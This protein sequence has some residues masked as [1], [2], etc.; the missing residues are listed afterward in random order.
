[1][2]QCHLIYLQK[3]NGR[4]ILF[5]YN[6]NIRRQRAFGCGRL[7]GM[8]MLILKINIMKKLIC[9]LLI[10]ASIKANAQKHSLQKIWET[11]SIV[12]VPESILP[13]LKNNTLY[14]SL[15]NGGGWIADGIGGVGKLSLDGKN[16][17][18]TWITGLN[19]PKGL[20]RY[21]NRMYTADIS[22][23]VV[24]DIQ[25]GKVEKK[26]PI[27]N[28]NGLNDITVD[29]KGIVYVSDSRKAKIW[30]IE[31]DVPTLFLDLSLIHI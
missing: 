28:A 20:G 3:L 14:I 1:M 4:V 13:D 12:A 17:D 10:C 22:E 27:K 19:A 30:R 24:I 18:S 31:D 21:G 5:K 25:K 6:L 8:W 9:L 26:I 11:D 23:V 15:I 16:Y 29:S 7:Q 2:N